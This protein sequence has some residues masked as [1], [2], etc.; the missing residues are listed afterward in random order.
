MV[1]LHPTLSSARH[2]GRCC[3]PSR[4]RTQEAIHSRP[5]G[6]DGSGGLPKSKYNT[7]YTILRHRESQV[8]DIVNMQGES[9][10]A[11]WFPNHTKKAKKDAASAV[12]TP[13]NALESD[14]DLTPEEAFE[15]SERRL[16]LRFL[17]SCAGGIAGDFPTLDVT[18][19]CRSSLPPFKPPM[20]PRATAAAFLVGS[21]GC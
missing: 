2:A 21:N 6:S 12:P 15:K 17:P 11:A 8:G 3:N 4:E 16:R 9:G 7:V 10:F 19:L 20:R 1:E 13:D 14:D 18:E 5:H